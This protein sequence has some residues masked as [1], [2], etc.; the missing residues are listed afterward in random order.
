MAVPYRLGENGKIYY[1]TSAVVSTTYTVPSTTVD[2]VKDVKV[3]G[4]H[5]T[6]EYTTRNNSGKKQFAVS[7][8]DITVGFQLKVPGSGSSDT[9]YAAI[10]DAW[11]NKTE[12]AIWALTDDKAVSGSEG[13]AGNFVVSDFSIEEGNGNVLFANVELKPSSYNDWY[14][15]P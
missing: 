8:T 13:P 10:R 4:K 9:A 7:L 3:S 2:N 1:Q 11:K 6:P 5:D 14:V 12:I 15:V